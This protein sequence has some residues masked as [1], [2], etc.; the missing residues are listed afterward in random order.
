M[1]VEEGE[2]KVYSAVRLSWVSQVSDCSCKYGPRVRER[3]G[4]E[5]KKRKL[6]DVFFSENMGRRK[7]SV[8][9]EIDYVDL[10]FII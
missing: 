4:R 3:K 9:Q 6:K 10:L 7:G 8:I 2:G 5:R 1:T